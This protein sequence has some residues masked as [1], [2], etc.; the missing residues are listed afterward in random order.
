MDEGKISSKVVILNLMIPEISSKVVIL[1]LMIPEI[2]SKVVILNLM[3]PEISE[4]FCKRPSTL[5]NSGG[6]GRRPRYLNDCRNES[7]CKAS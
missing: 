6:I 3:I 2:S 1:N 4:H 7:S 5:E